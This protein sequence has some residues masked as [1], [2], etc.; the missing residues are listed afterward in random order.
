MVASRVVV[1]IGLQKSGTTY[2]QKILQ[3]LADELAAAGVRYPLP[4]PRRGRSEFNHERATYGLIGT[5][6]TW[7]SEQRRE[8]ARGTWRWLV[9]QVR[10]HP[11]TV[12]L[13]AEAL[14]VIRSGGIHRLVE[15]L[16]G[17][18]DVVV[19]ARDL[20][21]ILP[22][23]WQQHL[24][25]GR[26]SSFG[27]YL[28]DLADQRDRPLEDREDVAELHLWRAFALGGLARRWAKV[29]GT[30]RIRVVTSPRE[31]PAEQLWSRFC[32]AAEIPADA[33]RPSK[34][35]LRQR[36]HTGLTAP[37][38]AV[39][40][41]LNS[42]LQE[43]G[44]DHQAAAGLRQRIIVNGFAPLKERGPRIVVPKEWR[45]RIAA[46]SDE[47]VDQLIDTGVPILGD[48][49]DLR[50]DPGYDDVPAPSPEDVARAAAAAVLTANDAPR[51]GAAGPSAVLES[52]DEA[53]V[54]IDAARS[55]ATGPYRRAAS[56]MKRRGRSA[57]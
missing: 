51:P 18:I 30:D 29:V 17:D 47:D 55:G 4:R 50:Y 35:L 23:L 40:A 24:R 5:E 43:A 11:G 56:W 26:V 41:S 54:D 25:N 48:A 49:D 3:Q 22:S 28:R 34:E 38:A 13:S 9:E 14:S 8:Q 20:G 45:D 32:R 1:H 16:G 36:T 52:Q 27:G 2:L 31:A 42:A 6:Y 53:A 46:W 33:A 57:G 39:L 15:E 12:L 7:V 44:W 37:E 10:A 19:T 21:R